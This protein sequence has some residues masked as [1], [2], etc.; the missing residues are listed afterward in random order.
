MRPILFHRTDT[1][2]SS[3][4]KISLPHECTRVGGTQN[5]VVGVDIKIIYPTKCVP[6]GS[7][8]TFHEK[9]GWYNEDVHR[10]LRA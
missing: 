4:F 7:T 3:S 6:M 8:D 9:E 10:L 2:I 1:R 5:A